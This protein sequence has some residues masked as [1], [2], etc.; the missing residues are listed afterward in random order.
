VI[1]SVTGAPPAEATLLAT[2]PNA[3]ADSVGPIKP[4]TSGGQSILI[5]ATAGERAGTYSVRIK[6]PGYLD[7]TRAGIVVTADKCHVHQV[8]M[9]SRLQ[10]P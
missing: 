5:L 3:F 9:T 2:S 8:T 6:S 1:D 10:K 4:F 7:W